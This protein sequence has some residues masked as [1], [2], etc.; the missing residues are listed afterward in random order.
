MDWWPADSPFE[1]IVGAILTQNAAWRNVEQALAN[2]ERAGVLHPDGLR[3]LSRARLERLIR[4]SGFFRVKTRR[5]R[6]FLDFLFDR[7]GGS[8][9]RLLRTP[10]VRLRRELLGVT[11]IGPETADSIILYAGRKPEFVVDAYTRRIF[12]RHGFLGPDVSYDETKA[13]FEENLPPEAPLF[14][15]Y[16][17]LIVNVGKDWCRPTPRC[18]G[19]PLEWHPH[20]LPRR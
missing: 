3:G 4:P 13:L 17:A 19:C 18:E 6:A 9:V 2:L 12:H 11:G 10:R 5:L 1:M 8:V 14:N 15:E 7:H 20:R 16:H